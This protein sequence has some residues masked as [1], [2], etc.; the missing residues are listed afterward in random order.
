[1]Q[2][3]SFVSGIRVRCYGTESENIGMGNIHP[4][5]THQNSLLTS[6]V[7]CPVCGWVT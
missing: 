2:W 4:D 1:M 3:Y 5:N 7:T 6:W